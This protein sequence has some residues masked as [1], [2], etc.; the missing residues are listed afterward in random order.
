[1]TMRAWV[2]SGPGAGGIAEVPDAE[3]GDY[4]A[5]VE[6]LV[7]GIC[8]STDKM[9]RSG[10]FR[11]G[12]TYPSVLGHESVGR[13]TRVGDKVR[14]LAVGDLV[15]RPSAYRPDLAPMDQYWGGFATRGVVTDWTAVL[16]DDAAIGG[17]PRFDQVVLPGSTDPAL[18]SLA[19]SLSET[20][21]VAVRHDLLGAR[22]AVVGTGIA[23]LSFVRYA[24]LLGAETVLAVGRRLERLALATDLGADV[25][26]LAD[27]AEAAAAGLGGVDVVFEASGQASMT[28]AGYRWVRSGGKVV[29][30]SA[31]DTAAE[32]DLFT[33]PRDVELTVASTHEAA[34]LPQMVRLVETGA[35][36]PE[37]FLTHRYPFDDMPRAFDEIAR[38]GVVK[39][40][41]DLR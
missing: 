25:V 2:M 34:V 11:L 31:P 32:I 27:Q 13:V 15:T 21:S 28:A 23:G 12:V 22:V 39:A 16:E 41:V 4:D 10:T 3:T 17:P 5:E 18:A 36:D 14:G 38:G 33:G 29:V 26:A 8:S 40:V 24:K 7:C 35:I 6:M 1:V 20:Y 37:V 9:L 30:Y 19:I